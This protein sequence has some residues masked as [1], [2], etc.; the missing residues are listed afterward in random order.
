MTTRQLTPAAS[1][2]CCCVSLQRNPVALALVARVHRHKPKHR[3]AALEEGGAPP[4]VASGAA[5]ALG[6]GVVHGHTAALTGDT[7]GG[8]ATGVCRSCQ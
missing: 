8:V 7:E 1:R 3:V 4:P 6:A 2:P 5:G